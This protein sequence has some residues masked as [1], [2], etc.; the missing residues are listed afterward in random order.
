MS[1]PKDLAYRIIALQHPHGR[2]TTSYCW[3]TPEQNDAAIERDRQHDAAKIRPLIEQEHAALLSQVAR[4]R[5]GLATTER[6][7][8]FLADNLI[9]DET[10]AHAS[11]SEVCRHARAL[12]AET[13]G[14]Q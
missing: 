1:A 9:D 6:H 2:P 13:E 3:P 14:A 5:E 10:A 8:Q 12:L 7:L 11:A 4:L